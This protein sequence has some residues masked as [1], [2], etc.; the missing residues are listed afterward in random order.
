M[1]T[2]DHGDGQWRGKRSGA[3]GWGEVN[4]GGV[5]VVVGGGRASLSLPVVMECRETSVGVEAL[6]TTL[7][8]GVAVITTKTLLGPF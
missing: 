8:L 1:E 4:E 3:D 7:S 6:Q 2:S 5:V